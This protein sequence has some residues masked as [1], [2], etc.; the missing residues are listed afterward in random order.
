MKPNKIAL[1]AGEG[2]LPAEIFHQCKKDEIEIKILNVSGGENFKLADEDFLPVD[3]NNLPNIIALLKKE[4]FNDLVFAGRVEHSLLF[5]DYSHL[6]MPNSTSL[7][8]V[9]SQG[10]NSYFSGIV[11]FVESLGFCVI[12]VH[13]ILKESVVQKELLTEVHPSENC[14]KDIQLGFR[15]AK[16]I[17][18]MD[19]GQA[20]IL[21]NGYVLGVEAI[22]G[23]DNLIKRCQQFK[24]PHRSGVLVK[25]KK[26]NQEIRIDLPVIGETTIKHVFKANLAGVALEAGASILINKEQ[27][28]KTA[29]QLGLFIIGV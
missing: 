24:S 13:E 12:G 2:D 29:N 15:I 7:Q 5:E 4:G 11:Q 25:I 26:K 22:E 9:I 1:I 21:E 6:R 27:V 19:I 17:G 23:T 3:K 28:I 14:Q 10:D 8:E 16:N 18:D 20:V